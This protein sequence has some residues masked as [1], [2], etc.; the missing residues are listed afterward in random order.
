[1]FRRTETRAVLLLQIAVTWLGACLAP[2][3]SFAAQTLPRSIL[4]LEQSDV[5]SP[6]Y[7]AIYSGLLSEVNASA[8]SPVTIYVENLDLSRFP[9]P[10]YEQSLRAHLEVKYRDIPLG[11]IL[12]VG[13]VALKYVLERRSEL[14]PGIPIVFAFVDE[15][16]I[17]GLNLPNDVTGQITHLRLQDMVAA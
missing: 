5:R 16:T 13:P 12:T 4:I 9:R 2:V 7:A 11:T 1:M 6:F 3:P 15:A 17:G 14:W 10:E 8:N